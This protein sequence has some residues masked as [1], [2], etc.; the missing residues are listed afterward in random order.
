[1]MSM[2][3]RYDAAIQ[4]G[5][6]KRSPAQREAVVALD[7][8]LNDLS[9]RTWFFKR[10]SCHG[11]YLYGSVGVGK[12]YVLD[13]FYN[14]LPDRSKARFHFHRFMQHIDAEL[15]RLQ[16][17]PDPL[18]SVA[19]RL[20]RSARV[21]CL[22]EFLVHDVADA[23][24]LVDLLKYLL[25][26]GVVF[27]ITANT[28]P[29]DLYLGGVHRERFI[30]AIQLIQL[31]CMV[32][33]LDEREDHRLGKMSMP[34]TYLTPCSETNEALLERS[35]D[36][37]AGLSSSDGMIRIQ[38]RDIFYRKKGDVAIWFDFDV[39]C[40]LPRS[41]LDYLELADKFSIIFVTNVPA[42]LPD[43][44][45]RAVLLIHFI[46]VM[47]DRKVR[48]VLSAAT[49]VE[50]IYPRGPMRETFL[51]TESRLKE[52]QSYEYWSRAEASRRLLD[53]LSEE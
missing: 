50:G 3:Q 24:I 13:L 43:D 45:T 41:Q 14:S 29:D 34:Q 5:E 10:K 9:T 1:M 35:F 36:E 46:D 38:Y 31:H 15:R 27:V 8:L 47:Y 11:L 52:M 37:L 28:R 19:K 51:R 20:A 2:L 40:G 17:T 26:F 21:L 18:K 12:T 33:M 6:I 39:I 44:T 32:M 7:N 23:M 30:P 16:G 4:S 42:I 49:S 53:E 48:L 25:S 22:D